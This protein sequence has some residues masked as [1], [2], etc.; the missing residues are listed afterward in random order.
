MANALSRVDSYQYPTA[1]YGHL[2]EVQQAK[3]DEFKKI[4]QDKGYFHPAGDNGRIVASHDDET[5]LY[6]CWQ[7]K[8]SPLI[9][10]VDI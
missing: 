4:S 1:H 10:P 9:K 6:V 2:N 7:P 8:R 5:L 3:L